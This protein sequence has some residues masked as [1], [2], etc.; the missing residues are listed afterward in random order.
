MVEIVEDF[1]LVGCDAGSS[2]SSFWTFEGKY[3]LNSP[4]SVFILTLNIIT[5]TIFT[6]YR[7]GGGVRGSTKDAEKGLLTFSAT[8][9]SE[10]A[11]P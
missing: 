7:G 9:T 1:G 6:K 4:G 8:N 10:F 11:K 2:G 3:C 5:V